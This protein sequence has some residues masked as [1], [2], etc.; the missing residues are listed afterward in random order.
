MSITRTV[1]PTQ[2]PVSLDELK[3]ALKI[4]H[5]DMDAT[6][7]LYLLAATDYC[8]EYQWA[9]YVTATFV[10]RFDR[11]PSVFRPQ[12]CPLASV[13]SLAYVDTAGA[14][15]TLTVTTHYTVDIYS[16]PGRIVPAYNYSW[17][18]TYGHV[19]DVTLT[20]TAGYGAPADVPD[21]IKH[22]IL[23][24]AAQQYGD[25]DAGGNSAMDMAIH[26]LL[27]KRSFRV[28]Y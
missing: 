21:E 22:A 9:Q 26:S 13:T 3:A 28:F 15:Q 4:T 23:L 12:R 19:N 14:S 8:Q 27:D 10:E 17:P 18:A 11:F 1:A 5:G 25:C 24:K 16:K 6:L 7:Q 2:T 20:Y